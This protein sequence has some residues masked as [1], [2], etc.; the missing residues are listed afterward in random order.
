MFSGTGSRKRQPRGLEKLPALGFTG[1]GS[2]EVPPTLGSGVSSY[3]MFTQE[4]MAYP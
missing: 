1:R 3:P 2:W 4:G